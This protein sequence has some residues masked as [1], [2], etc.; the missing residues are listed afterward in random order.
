MHKI[1]ILIL[2]TQKDTSLT[3]AESDRTSANDIEDKDL[4]SHNFLIT[5]ETDDENNVQLGMCYF[6]TY[7]VT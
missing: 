4:T 3:E 7:G 5:F 6:V 1:T 2:K